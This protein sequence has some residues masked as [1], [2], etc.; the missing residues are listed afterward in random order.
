MKVAKPSQTL[1]NRPP[2]LG[3]LQTFR[4][5]STSLGVEPPKTWAK[6]AGFVPS[7]EIRS[8]GKIQPMKPW[9]WQVALVDQVLR[10]WAYRSAYVFGKSRQCG[11][12]EGLL[13]LIL[14]LCLISGSGLVPGVERGFTAL[15]ASR[16]YQDAMLL[17]RRLRRMVKSLGLKLDTDS[18]NL[19]ALPNGSTVLFRSADPDSI[20]RGIESVNMV[21]LDE[22]S[23]YS[24]QARTLEAIAPSMTSVPNSKLFTV[25]TPNGKGDEFWRLLTSAVPELELERM[26][27]EIRTEQT[28]PFQIIQ[29]S[30]RL[31]LLNWR[32][33]Y[34]HKKDTFLQEIKEEFNLTEVTIRQEYE[35]EFL[36]ESDNFIF[37]LGLVKSCTAGTLLPAE[38]GAIYYAGI[39]VATSSD[40]NSDYTVCIIIEKL[41]AK[42]SERYRVVALY[43]R[44]T[45][46]SPQHLSAIAKLIEAYEPISTT[47]ETNGPGKVWAESLSGLSLPT[48]LESFT[49]SRNSKEA[50]ISRLVLAME[51]EKLWI[52]EGPIT[53][54]L[55]SFRR[56]KNG[57]MEA[58]N[59]SHDDC[60]I[61]LGLAL[62]GA[63]KT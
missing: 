12:S 9:P 50:L 4:V 28:A 41:W 38:D 19:V 11:A 33:V 26:L 51:A 63:T 5:S 27:E 30:P 37:P 58:A 25:S 32:E 61:S 36:S 24:E 47:I 34:G 15:V 53:E 31:I 29:G 45:G 21:V 44:R 13:S 35:M 52:P 10:D 54:E 62:T 56:N 43:R 46:S 40:Q 20:G 49:T 23:F 1:I 42:G 7:I 55:L 16:T 17:G 18:L 2:L 22:F 8:G 57:Q 48:E 6:W 60:V 3:P 59:N 14:W 39:D